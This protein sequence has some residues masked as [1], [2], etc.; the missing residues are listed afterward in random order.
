[1]RQFVILAAIILC[2]AAMTLGCAANK[3][4]API[5]VDRV[6]IKTTD[7]LK[8]FEEEYK[9]VGEKVEEGSLSADVM[10]RATAIR[11]GLQKYLIKTEAELE[12]LRL[13]VLHGAESQRQRALNQIVELVAEREQTKMSHLQELQALKTG[14]KTSED[15]TGKDLDIQIKIAPEDIGDGKRP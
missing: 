12:I 2:T 5:E 8:A 11:M 10:S 4:A 7:P 3:S 14:G 13:D 1:M 6:E 15:K 9:A